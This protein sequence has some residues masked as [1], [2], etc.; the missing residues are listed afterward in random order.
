M[1]KKYEREELT[2]IQYLDSPM[3]LKKN[4]KEELKEINKGINISLIN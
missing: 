3:V 1:Q 2:Y 4:W